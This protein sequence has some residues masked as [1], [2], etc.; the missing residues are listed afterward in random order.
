MTTIKEG[1]FRRR[2]GAELKTRNGEQKESTTNGI[3]GL[4][5]SGYLAS[6]ENSFQTPKTGIHRPEEHLRTR[7]ADTDFD[8]DYHD[9]PEHNRIKR[10]TPRAD[11]LMAD[12]PND[13]PALKMLTEITHCYDLTYAQDDAE[14]EGWW[15]D[16]SRGGGSA[17]REKVHVAETVVTVLVK[18]INDNAPVF[19]NATMFGK[20]RE[21]G[22]PGLPVAVVGAWD[23][24]DATE[25]TNAR[26]TYAIEK[27]VI[28][29]ESGEAIFTVEPLTGEVTTALCCLDRETTPEY[30]I[31]V[32][33]S[34]EEDSR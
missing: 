33:A 4:G 25:G 28:Q 29:E 21:N 12:D 11:I 23:A 5:R 3:K 24:D 13:D 26:L 1:I 32:V 8:L 16:D 9:S 6:S 7:R 18:D 27:N 20:V 34:T 30:S 22:E 2:K 19:P 31:Q 17:A 14:R 10:T 15:F